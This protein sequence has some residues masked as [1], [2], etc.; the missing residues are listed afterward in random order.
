MVRFNSTS[1]SRLFAC[2][3]LAIS[4]VDFTPWSSRRRTAP[5]ARPCGLEALFR[6]SD[7]LGSLSDQE[8]RRSIRARLV[9]LGLTL[10]CGFPLPRPPPYF[11]ITHRVFG[12]TPLGDSTSPMAGHF[13]MTRIPLPIA[14]A[15]RH[16]T[17]LTH[18][19]CLG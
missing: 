15:S 3:E 16:C 19:L 10:R 11:I 18:V 4:A 7:P 2:G 17:G 12:P 5:L 6:G 9:Q 13:P 1:T 8:E 14:A